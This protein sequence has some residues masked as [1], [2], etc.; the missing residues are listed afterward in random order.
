MRYKAKMIYIEA[1]RFGADP[2]PPW[3]LKCIDCEWA[4]VV[5]GGAVLRTTYNT[6]EFALEGD[7]IVQGYNGIPYRMADDD[8]DRQ[9]E[10]CE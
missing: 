1:F 6:V 9:Y 4:T 5:S 10:P 7:W 8:F 3:F 2:Q